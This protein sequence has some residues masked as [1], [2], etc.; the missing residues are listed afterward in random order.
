M[1]D[2]SPRPARMMSEP[3]L[4]ADAWTDRL[5]SDGWVKPS[6][7]VIAVQEPATETVLT[8]VGRADR[9]DVAREIGRAH[10]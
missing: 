2:M 10:V 4:S 6:G 7:G 8:Q 5:F 1:N 3:L 9:S